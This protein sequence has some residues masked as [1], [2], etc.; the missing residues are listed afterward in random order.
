MRM[1]VVRLVADALLDAGTHDT[2]AV[3]DDRDAITR[4]RFDTYPSDDDG[5]DTA[6]NEQTRSWHESR[7]WHGN[8][9]RDGDDDDGDGDH[10]DAGGGVKATRRHARKSKRRSKS[11][12]RR[13]WMLGIDASRAWAY[14]RQL[15]GDLSAD[16]VIMHIVSGETTHIRLSLVRVLCGVAC[17]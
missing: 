1:F 6:D 17:A 7:L 2:A 15:L 13:T 10:D 4:A 11:R 14:W 16:S 5:D 9:N 3:T 8:A 12:R